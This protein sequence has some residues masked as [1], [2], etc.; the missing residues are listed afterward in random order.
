[1]AREF[2]DNNP[3][4]TLPRKQ[5]KSEQGERSHSDLAETVGRICSFTWLMRADE[6]FEGA[7]GYIVPIMSASVSWPTLAITG[8]HLG[9]SSPPASAPHSVEMRVVRRL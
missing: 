3:T 8:H 1:V 9:W 7:R 2:G 4:G 6:M 5:G